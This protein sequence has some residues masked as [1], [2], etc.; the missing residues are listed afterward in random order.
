VVAD[1]GASADGDDGAGDDERAG[2]HDDPPAELRGRHARPGG[3]AA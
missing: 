3:P 2:V 1:G